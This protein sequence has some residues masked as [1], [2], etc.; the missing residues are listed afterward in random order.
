MDGRQQP[1]EDRFSSVGSLSHMILQ[2]SSDLEEGM[3]LDQMPFVQ[4]N[5]RQ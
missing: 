3:S 1:L 4:F 2:T 5:L